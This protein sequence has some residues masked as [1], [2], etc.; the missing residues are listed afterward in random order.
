MRWILWGNQQ[1]QTPYRP[2]PKARP[3]M[4]SLYRAGRVARKEIRTM[5]QKKFTE[6]AQCAWASHVVLDPKPA[7]SWRFCNE[8]R[9]LN[10]VTFRDTCPLPPTIDHI[11]SLGEAQLFTT[12]DSNFGYWQ[13]PIHVADKNKTM[14]TCPSG[15][16]RI[17]RMPQGLMNAPETFQPT[18]DI[19][20]SWLQ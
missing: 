13:V 17:E 9:R 18:L 3:V 5:T 1:Y 20:L 16:Y 14:F 15:T 10:A 2:H 19:L 6:P 8:Y 4:S 7:G 11:D 12:L